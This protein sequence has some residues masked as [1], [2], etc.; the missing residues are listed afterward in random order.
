VEIP[1]GLKLIRHRSSLPRFAGI[2][3]DAWGLLL[4]TPLLAA[5]IVLNNEI[6]IRE[7]NAGV[8]PK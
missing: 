6:Y 5:S 3:F 2:L 4:A 7:D 1:F 8:Q